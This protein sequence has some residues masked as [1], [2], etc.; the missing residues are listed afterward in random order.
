MP[1]GNCVDIVARPDGHFQFHERISAF[2]S[3][4]CNSGSEFTSAVY[5]S[6]ETAEAAARKKFDFKS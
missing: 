2:G 1:N 5:T 6:A 3:S 4:D